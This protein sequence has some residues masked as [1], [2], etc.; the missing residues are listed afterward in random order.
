M[1]VKANKFILFVCQNNSGRSQ[2]AQA[3]FNHRH[4]KSKAI[5]AGIEPD[6]KIHPWTIKV[7]KEVGIDVS[8][9]KTRLLTYELMRKADKIIIMDSS[10]KNYLPAKFLPKIINWHI[11][12][13]QGKPIGKVRTI[14]DSIE[15]CI[16]QL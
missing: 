10:I 3:F 6:R 12:Q 13:P 8:R 11:K 9:Q 2:M 5:S 15:K 1:K 16:S 4:Q 7:M 14:R